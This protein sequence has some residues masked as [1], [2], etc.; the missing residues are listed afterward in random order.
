MKLKDK[1]I[2]LAEMQA[3][4][5]LEDSYPGQEI[6]Q[7]ETNKSI[8]KQIYIRF[9][10]IYQYLHSIDKDHSC[11]DVHKDWRKNIDKDFKNIKEISEGKV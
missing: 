1:A 4:F 6:L 5:G 7:D 11:H 10:K 3:C 9:S 8:E 2:K